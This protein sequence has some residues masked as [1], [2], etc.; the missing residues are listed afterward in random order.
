MLDSLKRF[1][2][3][4]FNNPIESEALLWFDFFAIKIYVLFL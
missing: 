2:E 1:Q 3:C 4:P